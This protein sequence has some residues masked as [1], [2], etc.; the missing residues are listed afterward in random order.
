MCI[1]SNSFMFSIISVQRFQ[2]K[3]FAKQLVECLN[4]LFPE[5]WALD[6]LRFDVNFAY[7]DLTDIS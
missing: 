2:S 4:F 7:N 5:F 3:Q 1:S 6:I